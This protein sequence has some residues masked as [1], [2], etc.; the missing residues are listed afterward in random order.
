MGDEIAE[1]RQRRAP[2]PEQRLARD[3][4]RYRFLHERAHERFDGHASADAAEAARSRGANVTI[5]VAEGLEQGQY[6][7]LRPHVAE[8]VSRRGSSP[9][10]AVA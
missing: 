8:G 5:P 1:R 4:R 3:S 6:R 7:I 2:D 10:T 9:P